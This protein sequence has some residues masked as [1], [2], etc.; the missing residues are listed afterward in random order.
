[1]K[2]KTTPALPLAVLFVSL[3]CSFSTLASDLPQPS[4]TPGSINPEVTQD[5]VDA[6]ICVKGWTKTIRPPAYYTNKLKKSQLARYGYADQ[7][8]KHYEEDHLIPLELGGH[9]T[10][11]A[12]LWPQSWTSDWSAKDKDRLENTLKRLVCNH[13][14]GLSEAQAAI[15]GDWITAYKRYVT[16]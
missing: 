7:D 9:P 10:D 14:L 2:K 1:M 16:Q 4:L 11:P 13:R 15:A 6:T 12:N 3:A 5:A 8:P